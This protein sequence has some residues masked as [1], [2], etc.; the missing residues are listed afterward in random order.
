VSTAV[1]PAWGDVAWTEA[2]P[3]TERYRAVRDFT[4]VLCEPLEIED[5]V[6]Q[7][8]TEASPTKWHIAHTTW[9]FEQFV[10]SP[11]ADGY[12]PY[13]PDFAFLFNSYYNAAGDRVARPMRG[14]MTRPSVA[15]VRRYR[16]HVDDA[17][18]ALLDKA[19]GPAGDRLRSLVEIGLNHE[20]QHQELL[21][22]DLKHLLALNPL[23]PAYHEIPTA[24]G[25]AAPDMHWIAF[26][27][28]LR[29]IGHD[30][31]GFAYDNEGPRH[32][33]FV[34]AFEIADR[35]VTNREYLRFMEDG[36][37]ERAELWLDDGWAAVAAHGWTAPG[38]WQRQDGAWT[39]F[40]LAG[41]R[42]LD[43]DEPVCHVSLY[44]AA[45]FAEWV[46]ARLPTEAEWETA[47]AGQPIAGNL[48]DA[49]RFHPAVCAADAPGP[50]RQAAG[51]AWEWTQSA[52]APYPGYR[53]V[54]G[55][56]GEYNGK[57]MCSQIVLRGGSCAT[58]STH[59]RPTYRN[60]FYPGARWQFTG[61][62]LA[63]GAG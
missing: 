45:A 38:Y 47:A 31:N 25:A 53:P 36:G 50:L 43:L 11:L 12:R 23:H 63:R 3:L 5:Y 30:G 49:R 35:L 40:T 51:D 61:I 7:S 34:E 4:T 19:H 46:G 14:L 13:H 24:G 8:M 62:R 16:E 54:G 27:E 41:R 21:L 18:T 26:D 59:V 52:Y 1:A 55:A 32:R 57:F 15:E 56:L 28:G 48:A 17:V 44:E 58:H 37:Y 6:A 9:F 22:T 33:A 2:G 42:P 29:W 20:Q 10:L 60:F 39:A